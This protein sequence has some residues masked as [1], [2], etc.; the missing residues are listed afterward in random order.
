MQPTFAI[1]E[2][3]PTPFHLLILLVIGI[4]FFGKG[5]P[6]IGRSLGKRIVEFKEGQDR[7]PPPGIL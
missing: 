5:L 1:V 3:M 2:G 6:K 4:L 7:R